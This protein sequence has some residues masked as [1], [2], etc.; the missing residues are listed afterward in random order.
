MSLVISVLRNPTLPCVNPSSGLVCVRTLP[1]LT[2]L[3][4]VLQYLIQLSQVT[5][6]CAE[7]NFGWGH[8]ITWP[9][10]GG[11]KGH[12]MINNKYLLPMGQK[13]AAENAVCQNFWL[14]TS[15][16]QLRQKV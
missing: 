7:L 8:S 12:K 13:H 6:P 1:R 2:C 14:V 9:S 5:D 10:A 4:T 3:V 11:S 15:H 16:S